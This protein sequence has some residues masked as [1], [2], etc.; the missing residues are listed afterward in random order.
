MCTPEHLV[1]KQCCSPGITDLPINHGVHVLFE[2]KMMLL[3]SNQYLQTSFLPIRWSDRA[4]ATSR[5]RGGG[6]G[7]FTIQ[8]KLQIG[9]TLVWYHAFPFSV[10]WAITSR[11]MGILNTWRLDLKIH[12]ESPWFCVTVTARGFFISYY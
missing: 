12:S 6:Q 11:L 9:F 3:K 10:N 2:G 7:R 4:C 8:R 1:F 5:L